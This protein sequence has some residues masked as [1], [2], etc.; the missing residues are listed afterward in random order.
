MRITGP[1][2]ADLIARRLMAQK[3]GVMRALQM[4]HRVTSHHNPPIAEKSRGFGD[5]DRA[6]GGGFAPFVPDHELAEFDWDARGPHLAAG[7]S[8]DGIEHKQEGCVDRR[9]WRDVWGCPF[10]C[11]CWPCTVRGT[12]KLSADGP[13]IQRG[14]LP[15]KFR[16][17]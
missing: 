4:R 5:S 11:E 3:A 7:S 2:S 14:C 9:G 17:V 16:S 12:G 13:T 10:C 6:V 1:R 8:R 15:V